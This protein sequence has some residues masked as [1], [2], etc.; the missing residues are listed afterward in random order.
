MTAR[1]FPMARYSTPTERETVERVVDT[2]YTGIDSANFSKQIK[3]Q[4]CTTRSAYN[5]AH[6][7]MGGKAKQLPLKP[8]KKLEKV[9]QRTPQMVPMP[10][11]LFLC[12]RSR[13]AISV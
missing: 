11:K 9:T 6:E 13:S 10:E 4:V 12:Q 3:D 5:T 8:L 7:E 1:T 2:I